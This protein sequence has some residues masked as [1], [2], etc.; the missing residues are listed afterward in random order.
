MT[1]HVTLS[2]IRRGLASSDALV[3]AQCV[4]ALAAL[5]DV[6]GLRC[7][8]RSPDGYVRACAAQALGGVRGGRIA[9]SLLRLHTDPDANVRCT[10]ARALADRR[11]WLA[12]RTLTRL[13]ADQH[14]VVRLTALNGL[15]TVAWPRAQPLLQAALSRE[16]VGWIRDAVA[17]LLR[18]HRRS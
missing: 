10:V 16:D 9:L 15:A 13:A 6:R 1:D 17:T 2:R 12:A 11:G 5:A 4:D 8:L 3:R 18:H 14:P 7:G